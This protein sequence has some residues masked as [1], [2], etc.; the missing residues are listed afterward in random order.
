ML[1]L[2]SCLAFSIVQAQDVVV[3]SVNVETI[4]L[5]ELKAKIKKLEK[6]S[7]YKPGLRATI[8]SLY[9]LQESKFGLDEKA[10]SKIEKRKKQ[11]QNRPLAMSYTMESGVYSNNRS[12]DVSSNS[13]GLNDSQRISRLEEAMRVNVFQAGKH[14]RK[15]YTW[16]LVSIGLWSS[17]I[18]CI[19][20]GDN[21]FEDPATIVGYA[22]TGGAMACS[23]VGLV[24]HFKAGKELR[25]AGNKITLK[26]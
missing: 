17:G 15:A 22:L 2:F 1:L 24:H 25:V 16:D 18:K 3:D 26:F 10:K 4:N 11:L 7:F 19:V 5:K 8:D 23:I 21:D 9:L 20:D 14:V 13:V 12:K 6:Q